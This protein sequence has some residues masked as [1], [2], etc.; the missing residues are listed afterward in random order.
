M[1]LGEFYMIAV[2]E[3]CTTNA[4]NKIVCFTQTNNIEKHIEKY[5]LAFEAINNRTSITDD[6]HKYEK[7]CLLIVDFDTMKVYNTD[8]ELKSDGLLPQNSVASI[9][10]LTFDRFFPDLLNTYATRFGIGRFN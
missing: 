10:N 7:V 2:N 6:F 9:Q 3:F 4:K 8:A 1:V 5:L